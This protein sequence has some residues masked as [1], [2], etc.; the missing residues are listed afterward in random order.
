MLFGLAAP[1]QGRALIFDARPSV[2]RLTPGQ[3]QNGC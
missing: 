2:G 1:L 3:A